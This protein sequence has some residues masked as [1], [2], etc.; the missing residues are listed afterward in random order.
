MCAVRVSPAP[1]VQEATDHMK[2]TIEEL[3]AKARDTATKLANYSHLRC[4][5]RLHS[6]C[7]T[8]PAD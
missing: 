8:L 1:V 3:R 6:A 2:E 7:C 5:P 4:A